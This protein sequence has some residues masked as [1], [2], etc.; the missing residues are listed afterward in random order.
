MPPDGNGASDDSEATS[1]AARQMRGSSGPESIEEG[2]S[3]SSVVVTAGAYS[4]PVPEKS[5]LKNRTST[6]T[7]DFPSEP[8]AG[9]L[10]LLSVANAICVAAQMPFA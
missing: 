5:K 6:V 8:L 1:R 7:L 3:F 9:Y 2:R 10:R 4:M